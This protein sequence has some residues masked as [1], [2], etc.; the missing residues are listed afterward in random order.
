MDESVVRML[1]THLQIATVRLGIEW[2]LY[3]VTAAATAAWVFVDAG[4]R[5]VARGR[6]GERYGWAVAT[7]LLLPVIL[8]IYLLAARPVGT[9]VACPHC[10]VP[11]LS[12]R[13]A[14]VHCGGA[15]DFDAPPSMWGSGDIVGV[16]L[17]FVLF[18]VVVFDFLA[19]VGDTVT[20]D[21]ISLLI[22]LQNV[23]LAGLA[24]YVVRRRYRRPLSALGIRWAHAPALAGLG[25]VVGLAALPISALAEA[26]GKFVIGAIIG[27]GR[28]DGLAAAEQAKNVLFAVL[29]GSLTVGELAW[30]LV[31]VC[32]VVP[33]GEEI[34]FRGFVYGALRAR[35]R[36]SIAVGLSALVFAIVHTEVF[37]FLPIF[38]LGAILAILYERTGTLL[39]GIVVHSVNNVVAVLAFL[40]KWNI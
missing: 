35:L 31:L 11:T 16:V 4:L 28:A 20:L 15:L 8:P 2:E 29:R 3:F 1:L 24:I 25:A 9:L 39:P 13:A 32:V 27:H 21:F 23:L 14:C 5:G 36:A 37:H 6:V 40:Y 38:I 22:V 30:L 26:V 10:R 34:F 12:H 33:I 18:L 17:V 7:F 19:F